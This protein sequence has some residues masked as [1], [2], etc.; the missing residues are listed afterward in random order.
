MPADELPD[1]LPEH[2]TQ[3]VLT[4]TL[5]RE[6]GALDEALALAKQVPTKQPWLPSSVDLGPRGFGLQVKGANLLGFVNTRGE[7]MPIRAGDW[8][9]I[10]PDVESDRAGLVVG[11]VRGP[12]YDY[13]YL[14]L[15]VHDGAGRLFDQPRSGQLKA[16]PVQEILR[17]VPVVVATR[18]AYHFGPDELQPQHGR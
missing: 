15:K 1:V 3:L 17:L 12:E 14:V 5:Q 2:V 13:T 7:P 16:Y 18:E 10:D 11:F 8:V 9:W 6:S 4:A